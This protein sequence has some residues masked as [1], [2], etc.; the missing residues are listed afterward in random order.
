MAS[1]CQVVT[2]LLLVELGL[3]FGPTANL[4]TFTERTLGPVG[5]WAAA[6]EVLPRPVT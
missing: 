4:A 2:S 3:W 6:G 1:H 5:K